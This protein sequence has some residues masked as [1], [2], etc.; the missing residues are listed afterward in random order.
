M[1]FWGNSVMNLPN[2]LTLARI[3]VLPLF[4]IISIWA[5]PGWNYVAFVLFVLA[6]VTD[7]LDGKI[8]RKQNIVTDFGRM[9]DPIADKLLTSTAMVILTY[10]GLLPAWISILLVARDQIVNPLRA[11]AAQ[12]GRAVSAELSG[13]LKTVF[14]MIAFSIFFLKWQGLALVFAYIAVLFAIISMAEYIYRNLDI[15][16]RVGIITYLLSF[17]DRCV[18]YILLFLSCE[19]LILPILPAFIFVA[20]DNILAGFKSVAQLIGTSVATRLSEYISTY[21]MIFALLFAMIWPSI[22]AMWIIVGASLVTIACLIDYAII[23]RRT[24][25]RIFRG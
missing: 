6:S 2:K 4:I 16:Q 1:M 25:M 9:V 13:K 10:H 15:I 22:I 17:V 7:L 19:Q 8:A 21:L 24:L 14:Q 3:A 11:F 5:F 12:Y 23:Y 18:L 20:R